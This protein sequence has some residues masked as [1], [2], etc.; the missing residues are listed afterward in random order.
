MSINANRLVSI[1]PRVIS[2]GS[3]DLET[4]GLI[5]TA[6]N[7]I[8]GNVPAMEF[9]TVKEVGE[10]FGFS[11][12]EYLAAQQY[13]TGVNNQSKAITTLWFGRILTTAGSGWLRA[14][15]TVT[16]ETLKAITDGAFG[17]KVDGNTNTLT[18]L[19]FS[20]ATSFGDVATAITTGLTG[21]VC[22]YDSVQKKFVITS[23]TTG[24]TSIIDFGTA[25]ASGTNL[26]A[27]LGLD[28][29]G[30]AVQSLGNDALTVAEN[31][32]AI[33][34]VTRN[35][36]GFTTLL[37]AS[38]SDAVSYAAWADVD[39]DYVYFYWSDDTT[40]LSKST[41]QASVP[42]TL[43]AYNT[44]ACLYGSIYDAVFMLAVG[45]SIKWNSSNALKTW[46]AK[47]A[48]GLTAKVLSDTEAE[49]LD[50][51]RTS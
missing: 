23:T 18:G 49:A 48:S 12:A 17:I 33:T 43:Q 36:V 28:A 42:V 51:I 5:L 39:D 13:F 14:G 27:L 31:M 19:D 47:N 9:N 45:A 10:F 21:A 2:G 29:S 40:L 38:D 35:F 50:S 15:K 26:T 3:A 30:G 6:N 32:D 25:P 7:S 11:S 4:N 41:N 46:F 44:T 20:S 16:L 8:Q 1:T 34:V 37:K 24:A 22:S